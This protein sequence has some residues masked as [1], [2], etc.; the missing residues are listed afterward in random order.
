MAEKLELTRVDSGNR[1]LPI[2]ENTAGEACANS[3]L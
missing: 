2:I 3:N 1:V